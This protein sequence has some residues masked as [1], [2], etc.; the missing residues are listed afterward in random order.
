[1][2]CGCAWEAGVDSPYF[3]MP[4]APSVSSPWSCIICI[5]VRVKVWSVGDCDEFSEAAGFC[6]YAGSWKEQRETGEMIDP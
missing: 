4:P 1:M 5:A 3:P 2:Y 6:G